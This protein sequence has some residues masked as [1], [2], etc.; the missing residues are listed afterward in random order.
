MD[1]GAGQLPT[2]EQSSIW[3]ASVSG[4]SGA[5]LYAGGV[6][7]HG[8][9]LIC[10]EFREFWVFLLR[11]GNARSPVHGEL[12]KSRGNRRLV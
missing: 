2:S 4:A 1:V 12:L 7:V 5:E 6:P 11:C 10:P 9:L 8:E 3:T